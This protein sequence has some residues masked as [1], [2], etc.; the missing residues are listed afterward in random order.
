MRRYGR[1]REHGAVSEASAE[2]RRA[3]EKAVAL[4]EAGLRILTVGAA[5]E[6]VEH[7]F[8]IADSRI[9]RWGGPALVGDPNGVSLKT[10]PTPAVP[11]YCV[12]PYSEPVARSIRTSA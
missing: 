6:A 7:G 10:V 5:L 8:A 9:V 3:I 11:P 2:E 4:N 1:D 12:V